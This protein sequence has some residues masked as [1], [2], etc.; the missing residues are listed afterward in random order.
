MKGEPTRDQL[1]A[2]AERAGWKVR[3]GGGNHTFIYPPDGARPV[4]LS[5]NHSKVGA[6]INDQV[7]A[8]RR[9]GLAI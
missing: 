9:A 1:I 5:V 3:V 6:R 2:A 4:T 7:K 8:C